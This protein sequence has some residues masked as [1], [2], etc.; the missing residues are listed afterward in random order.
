MESFS[1]YF[2]AHKERFIEEWKEFLSFASIS[3]DPDYHHECVSC[4]EWLFSHL[5]GLGFHAEIWPTDTK[6][7]VY[8][9]LPGDPSR[10]AVL[11]YGH[12]DVQPVDPLELWDSPPFK[13]ELREGRMYARGAQDNKGQVFFVL[14]ALECLISR[15]TPLPTIK[16]IIEGEEECESKA[17]SDNLHLWR[18]PLKA[19]VLMVCDTGMVDYGMPTITMGLRGVVALEIRVFG[20]SIDLHSGIFGGIVLN[21][22]HALCTIIAGMFNEDGSI[23]IPGFYDGVLEPSPTDV[24]RAKSAPVMVDEIRASLGVPFAGGERALHP[25]VR[26]GLRPTIDVNGIGGGYQ[27]VG[28]KTVIPSY[29]AAKL[30][31]RTVVGQDPV[32]VLNSIKRYVREACPVGARV[33]FVDEGIGGKAFKLSAET[34]V[35]HAAERAI[36]QEFNRDP[37]YI[38]EGATVPIIPELAATSGAEPILVGFGLATDQIHSPNES[39]SLQ[40]LEEGFRYAA[41]FL[42]AV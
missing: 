37:F 21:P 25:S 13:P 27:G 22:L 33:E 26:R 1:S 32:N 29:G 20:P 34:G 11:F 6:P 14:K 12:Y 23:A 41:A 3:A 7:L 28:G 9:V 36:K 17:L 38:W 5:K 4:A 2:N 10:P 15:A 8:G 39:F 35:V 18:E 19:D 40:Q 31:S 30:S 42:S 24:E 16:I